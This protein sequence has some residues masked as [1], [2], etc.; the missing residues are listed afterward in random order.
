MYCPKYQTLKDVGR[1]TALGTFDAVK[2]DVL[3]YLDDTS[4]KTKLVC[5]A[6]DGAAFNFRVRSGVI[7]V[8]LSGDQFLNSTVSIIDLSWR[9]KTHV[10]LDQFL[11]T[12][13]SRWIFS[14]EHS[15]ALV[16]RPAGVAA[17]R[18]DGDQLVSWRH[19]STATSRCRGGMPPRRP[20]GFATA[21]LDGNGICS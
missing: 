15:N 20:A 4:L 12:S 3:F 7:N 17:A 13:R 10:M 16:R 14:I 18:L 11:K 5:M 2:G 8:W 21:C 1:C 9:M 19:A 6:M